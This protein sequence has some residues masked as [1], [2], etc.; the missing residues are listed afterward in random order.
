M[1]HKNRLIYTIEDTRII[2]IACIYHYYLNFN[3]FL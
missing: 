1:N 3:F 2:I